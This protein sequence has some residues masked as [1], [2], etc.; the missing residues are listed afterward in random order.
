MYFCIDRI[1][2]AFAVLISDNGELIK[3]GLSELPESIKEGSI[4]TRSPLGYFR[5]EAEEKN[6]RDKTRMLLDKMYE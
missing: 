3:L 1:D 2:G 6:R 5:D 4:L